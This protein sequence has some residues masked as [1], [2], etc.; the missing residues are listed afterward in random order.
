MNT[1]IESI[2]K[3]EYVTGNNDC[4]LYFDAKLFSAAQALNFQRLVVRPLAGIVL[5]QYLLLKFS[6]EFRMNGMGH[7]LVLPGPG[8]P[9]R[10]CDKYSALSLDDFNIMHY[11]A[12][13]KGNRDIGFQLAFSGYF[14]DP[15]VCDLH[16]AS[17]YF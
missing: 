16:D 5:V 14:P 17:P 3:L 6:A 15:N 12:I 11:E 13:V 1:G 10:H 9:T 7:I 8:L 4:G 2:C